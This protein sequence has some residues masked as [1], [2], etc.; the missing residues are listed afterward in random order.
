M[1]VLRYV[2]TGLGIFGWDTP[3]W[4]PPSFNLTVRKSHAAS[5]G[6]GAFASFPDLLKMGWEIP[7][8]QPSHPRPER[9]GAIMAGHQGIDLP[10]VVPK[11][12]WGWEI[13]PFQPPLRPQPAQR[14]AAMV[15]KDD[16]TQFPLI[17]FFP[18]DWDNHPFQPPHPRPEQRYAAIAQK[19]EG[20]QAQFI[21]FFPYGWAVP[22]PHPPHPHP[23]A[24]G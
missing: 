11:T 12:L 16:G 14:Y 24:A 22:S 23:A 20:I 7:S 6:K 17:Q 15:Q 3:S 5:R 19:D 10:L 8:F 18:N 2:S 1:M 9:A 21:Q 13:A 4:Q